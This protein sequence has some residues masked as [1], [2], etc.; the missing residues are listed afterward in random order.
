MGWNRTEVE[1]T[2]AD[3]L[4]M[5][6]LELSGQT[7]NKTTHR[8]GLLAKLDNRSESAI[9][10]KHRNISAILI[11]LGFPYITGYKPSG[12]YQLLLREV[13]EDRIAKDQ[14]LD[15]AAL[16]ASSAPAATPL[17]EDF[18]KLL[19]DAPK[20]ASVYLRIYIATSWIR[21]WIFMCCVL[22]MPASC[23]ACWIRAVLPIRLRP[24]ICKKNQRLRSRMRAFAA[25][26]RGGHRM[27]KVRFGVCRMG[28]SN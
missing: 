15:N 25:I 2:V 1:A 17:F 3:Y 19:V 7:Y 23:K 24:E 28:R 12:N 20:L 8:R 21:V 11:E 22:A 5:L 27:A 9:E 16:T 26:Q 18:G 10:F 13:V 4:H 14:L 6:L